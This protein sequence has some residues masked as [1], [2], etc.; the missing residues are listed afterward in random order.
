MRIMPEFTV[1]IHCRKSIV[2]SIFIGS[3]VKARLTPIPIGKI[4]SCH[5]HGLSKSESSLNRLQGHVVVGHS[6]PAPP[7]FARRVRHW[8]DV[9]K[10]V[11]MGHTL[12]SGA[13]PTVGHVLSSLRPPHWTDVTQHVVLGHAAPTTSDTPS[14]PE[15]NAL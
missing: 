12:L 11:I 7:S 14:I 1:H 9:M 6:L 4:S 15:G 5:A 3:S 13:T 2:N 8:T 10:H